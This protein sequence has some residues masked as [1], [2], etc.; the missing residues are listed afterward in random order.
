M[1]WYR[2][3]SSNKKSIERLSGSEKDPTNYDDNALKKNN[4]RI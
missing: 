1:H 4:L 2:D 3:K